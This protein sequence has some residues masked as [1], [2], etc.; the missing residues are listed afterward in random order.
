MG[1]LD[2]SGLARFLSKLSTH[3]V[4]LTSDQ[5][6]GGIKNFTGAPRINLIVPNSN[7]STV[8]LRAAAS[9]TNGA[10]LML[11]DKSSSSKVGC[12]RVIPR[13]PN[14]YTVL[15]AYPDGTFT[16]GGNAIQVASDE[17]LK[18][19]LSS[20][21]DNVLDAWEAVNWGQFQF[22]KAVERKGESARLHLG[23][24]AQRVKSVFESRGLDACRYGIL[25]HDTDQ[26]L[27]MVRYEEALAMEAA[28]QRRRADRLE[29]RIAALEERLNG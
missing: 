4:D 3:F 10:S 29:A 7:S 19:P 16:W 25:C 17:R 9:V 24:I 18:T 28:C 1:F 22:L 27:W 11:Y 14:G 15:E 20:V 21:P 23:L 26:D 13:T 12:F 6:I 8:E 5:E 2:E